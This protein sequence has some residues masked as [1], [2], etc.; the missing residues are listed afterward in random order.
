[1]SMLGGGEMVVCGVNNPVVLYPSHGL[2]VAPPTLHDLVLSSIPRN[3]PGAPRLL[4]NTRWAGLTLVKTDYR[5]HVIDQTSL[6][7]P[8]HN[9][10]VW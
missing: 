4:T 7:H 9:L 2:V 5:I 1:M 3:H 8:L 6:D 10:C